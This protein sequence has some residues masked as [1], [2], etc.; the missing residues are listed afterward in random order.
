[1]AFKA[2]L[3][4][5][6][7]RLYHANMVGSPS[8]NYLVTWVEEHGFET[9]K[10]NTLTVVTKGKFFSASGKATS[11][12]LTLLDQTAA[13]RA[14]DA[15]MAPVFSLTDTGDVLYAYEKASS[16]S[17]GVA[18]I[19]LQRCSAACTSKSAPVEVGARAYPTS[20]DSGGLALSATSDGGAFVTW[21]DPSTNVVFAR[22]FSPD[23]VALSSAFPVGSNPLPAYYVYGDA[24]LSTTIDSNGNLVVAWGSLSARVF[25]GH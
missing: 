13:T 4:S 23:N 11:G 9:G 6:S 7:M 17:P 14:G 19:Y 16:G 2:F 3:F 5:K 8:G 1:V 15:I 18:A 21:G 20:P 10:I 25:Q 24:N 12:S 22:A